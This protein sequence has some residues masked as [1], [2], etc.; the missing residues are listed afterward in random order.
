MGNDYY[1]T[2]E[3]RV[4]ADGHA[5]PFGEAYGYYLITKQYYERYHLPVMHTETNFAQGPKGDEAVNWLWKQW[6]NILRLRNEGV[7]IVGF[8]WYSLT[9]QV[10]WETALRENN[11][12]VNPLG[13]YD[14]DRNIRPAG[15]AYRDLVRAWGPVMPTQ[16]LYPRLAELPLAADQFQKPA[17][18][19]AA[20]ATHAA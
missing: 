20:K 6:S 12:T 13:L 9:D 2:S 15:I 11:G 17:Q 16:A 7:P 4:K 5:E 1:N 19:A 18:K 10:D 8:T 14:L 3:S